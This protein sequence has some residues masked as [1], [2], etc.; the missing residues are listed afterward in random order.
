MSMWT[1]LT[2]GCSQSR[3]P[4]FLSGGGV[5]LWSGSPGFSGEKD[6]KRSE[7]TS[8]TAITAAN[9]V[10]SGFKLVP[11]GTPCRRWGALFCV[12][13]TSP[14][15]TQTKENQFSN[16]RKKGWTTLLTEHGSTP[17]SSLTLPSLPANFRPHI[18]PPQNVWPP[19]PS[20]PVSRGK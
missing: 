3:T 13:G 17:R 6:C 9:S 14:S 7:P 2:G 10:S 16:Q 19:P 20:L 5:V 12:G 4:P 15:I 8:G 1:V 11:P 18:L